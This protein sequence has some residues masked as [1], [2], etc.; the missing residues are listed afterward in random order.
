MS[1]LHSQGMCEPLHVIN[2]LHNAQP[3]SL[4]GG[5]PLCQALV[6]ASLLATNN[7]FTR[8]YQV[9]LVRSTRFPYHFPRPWYKEYLV[10]LIPWSGEILDSDWL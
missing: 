7:T 4:V 9:L 8:Y 5:S 1:L 6:I 2:L 3:C 10:L